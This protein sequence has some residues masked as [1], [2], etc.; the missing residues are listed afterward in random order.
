MGIS[1][2]G[3]TKS[4]SAQK[5]AA[6]IATSAANTATGIFNAN[7][8][9]LNAITSQVQG[10]LPGIQKQ[11][12]Q[13]NPALNAAE[14]YA[15]NVLGGKYLNSGNPYLS[16][17][18]DATNRNVTNQVGAA[19]GSRGSFGGTAW[20]E[21]L[22]RTLAEA[23]NSL[24]YQDYSTERQNQQ[25]AMSAAPQMA[26]ADY[27]GIQPLLQ[28]AQTAAAL[29]YAGL[30]AYTGSL[31][32]LMNGSVTKGPG[33]GSSILGG[34]ASGAGMALAASDV[35]VKK[36]VS[37]VGELEDGLGVYDFRYVWENET[38]LHR[39]VMA[40]EVEKLRP[41]ALGP[42]FGDGYMTVDYSKLEAR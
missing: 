25:Q 40:Q 16:G 1:G 28:T 26:A 17:M 18:I 3:S 14:G 2:G 20:Q 41:W 12:E 19:Y 32:T 33:I 37:K 9:N 15:S 30:E 27:L 39:G 23:Q 4:G 6:P 13:G 24:R 34:L 38:P 36:D 7:Q 29:P 35:R 42:T 22:G 8:P 31:G 5:W 11:Y 10:L 21:N